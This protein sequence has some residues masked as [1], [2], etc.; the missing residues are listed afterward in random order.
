MSDR[1]SAFCRCPRCHKGFR[2]LADELTGAEC[3][4]CGYGH[5]QDDEPD[6][7]E[8]DDPL[9]QEEHNY[10]TRYR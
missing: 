4:R 9:T 5:E 8:M 2:V 1:E 7:D 3:P 6:E 10:M